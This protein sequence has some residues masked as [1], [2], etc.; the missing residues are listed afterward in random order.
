MV[1]EEEEDIPD[2]IRE[3]VRT[4]NAQSQKL[5]T[6]QHNIRERDA[7]LFKLCVDA[8][9]SHDEKRAKI[10]ADELSRIRGV[11]N[12]LNN[13]IVLME[14]MTIRLETYVEF[15]SFVTGLKP[16]VEA[17]QNVSK[18]LTEFMPQISN[19]IQAMNSNLSEVLLTTTI[20]ISKVSTY[21][22][23]ATPESES[24]LKEVSSLLGEKAESS[25]PEP[26]IVI[27]EP[28]EKLAMKE[29][30]AITVANT[31]GSSRAEDLL[32]SQLSES[33]FFDEILFDYL[34]E[35]G[36]KINL[37]QC[38]NDLNLSYDDIRKR[39]SRLKTLGKITIEE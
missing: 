6:I 32:S 14:C 21:I 26:P 16:I 5:K 29:N 8:V 11:R 2:E 10:Y 23:S 37:V 20:D 36:G 1:P 24:I 17:V 39:L 30:E 38:S 15:R 22:T 4:L 13:N 33:D 25:L 9:K 12:L 7:L 3:K 28:S 31:E 35:H 27:I 18:I 19:E 34:K